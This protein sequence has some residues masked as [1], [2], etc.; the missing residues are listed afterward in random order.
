MGSG[1][2]PALRVFKVVY[3]AAVV[4]LPLLAAF[5][6]PRDSFGVLVN[7]MTLIFYTVAAAAGYRLLLLI[8][9]H[10]TDD[11]AVEKEIE[12]SEGL[13]ELNLDDRKRR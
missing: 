2:P 6:V 7:Q 1:R 12:E 5:M 11:D 8:A 9:R 4:S 10:F 13:V 3:W